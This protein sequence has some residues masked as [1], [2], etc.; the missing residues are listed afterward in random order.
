MTPSLDEKD[1]DFFGTG[2]TAKERTSSMN[3]HRF[4]PDMIMEEDVSPKDI[5]ANVYNQSA[6]PLKLQKQLTMLH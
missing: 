6:P 4:V 2:Q 1:N 5:I 3:M